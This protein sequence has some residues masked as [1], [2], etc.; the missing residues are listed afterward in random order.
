[1]NYTSQW[2]ASF[3]YAL[4]HA[5][6]KTEIEALQVRWVFGGSQVSNCNDANIIATKAIPGASNPILE[7]YYNFILFMILDCALDHISC[8]EPLVA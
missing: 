6:S 5:E 7:F 4:D 2:W 3:A 1:M 8:I